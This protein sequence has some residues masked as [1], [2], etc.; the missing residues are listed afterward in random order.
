MN[1]RTSSILVA[2]LLLAVAAAAQQGY[3]ETFEVRLHNLEVVVTDEKGKPVRGLTKADFIVLENG[4]EQNV[5]NFSVYDSSTATASSVPRTAAAAETKPAETAGEDATPRR[6]VFFVDDMAVQTVA[7]N[8]LARQAV[9]LVDEMRPGDLAA[10]IRPTGHRVPQDYTS[11]TAAVRKALT[12]AIQSCTIRGDAPGLFELREMRSAMEIADNEMERMH[13]KGLYASRARERVRQRLS[14]LRALVG[15]MAAVEG[16]KV[17]LVITTGLPSHPGRDAIDFL[18]QMKAGSERLVTEWGEPG[19][20]FTPV[21]DEL[22]RTAA[23]NGV[24]IYALEPEVPL[25]LGIQKSAASRTVGSTHGA[26]RGSANG[27]PVAGGGL[28]VSGALNMPEQMLHELLHYRGQT[29]T[30]LADRTG[31]KWFRGV[32]TIDDMFRQVATDMSV[33]YSLAYRATGTR[34]QPRR[35]EVRIR[36]RPG[37]RARTRS[38]VIDRSPQREMGDL[39][40]ANL[41]FPSRLNELDVKVTVAGKIAPEGKLY[42]VPVDVAIPLGKLTFVQTADDKY[43]AAVDVHYAAAAQE[44]TFTVSGKHHQNIEISPAQHAARAGVIYRFKTGIQ[45]SEGPVRIAIGVMDTASRLAAFGNLDVV[46]K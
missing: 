9:K 46:A 4:V 40:A 37:L 19:V 15:S 44:N 6:F 41:L 20:D 18:D 22:G 10:V 35:I 34:D 5:T 14:Q 23:A 43:A 1:K 11:D 16:R 33:Y 31:G 27:R 28:S 21:I 25:S 30:S 32:G 24:T 3:F 2:M 8:N 38:E 12:A 7:R 26:V 45:V 42:A 36:N 17:L 29:L 13:A 39:T